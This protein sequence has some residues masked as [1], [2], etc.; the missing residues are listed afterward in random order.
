[1]TGY[2]INVVT[3]VRA[4]GLDR[5]RSKQEG[6][7]MA[8]IAFLRGL[9]GRCLGSRRIFLCLTCWAAPTISAALGLGVRSLAMLP[10][11]GVCALLRRSRFV[12][13][14]NALADQA[15]NG[16]DCLVVDRSDDRDCRTGTSG[17]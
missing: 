2:A 10:R 12:Q 6:R 15:F 8:S 16:V 17:A 14:G 1:G 7:E 5:D 11:R 4:S 3:R 13:P 9:I